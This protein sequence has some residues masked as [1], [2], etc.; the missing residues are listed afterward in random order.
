[1]VFHGHDRLQI[2]VGQLLDGREAGCALYALLHLVQRE[3]GQSLAV[4]IE[5]PCHEERVGERHQ[6]DSVDKQA[7]DKSCDRPVRGG[8]LRARCHGGAFP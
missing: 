1:M 8:A 4:L 7:P 3:C 6:Y 2:Q 5:A